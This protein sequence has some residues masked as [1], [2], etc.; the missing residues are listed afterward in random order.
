MV[1]DK[2]V[3]KYLPCMVELDQKLLCRE[4]KLRRRTTQY[5]R[6]LCSH[7]LI[8]THDVVYVVILTPR[9]NLSPECHA[10]LN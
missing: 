5:L 9:P 4:I 3:E 10:V 6:V 1:V 8:K 7:P 2:C